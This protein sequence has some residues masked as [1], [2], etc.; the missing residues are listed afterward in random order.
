MKILILSISFTLITFAQISPNEVESIEN[1]LENVDSPQGQF[2]AQN[3][4]STED[5]LKET[6]LQCALDLCGAPSTV[7]SVYITNKSF[8]ED[9]Q[10]RAIENQFNS[11]R[12]KLSDVLNNETSK[13]RKALERIKKNLADDSY[14]DVIQLDTDHVGN[15][16]SNFLDS[17][18]HMQVKHDGDSKELELDI[19]DEQMK[20]TFPKSLELFE[21]HQKKVFLANFYNKVYNDYYSF[22]EAKAY[23]LKMR[24]TLVTNLEKIKESN[25]QIYTSYQQGLNDQLTLEEINAITDKNEFATKFGILDAYINN[26][27][28]FL[29]E[30]ITEYQSYTEPFKCEEYFCKEELQKYIDEFKIAEKVA[31]FEAKLNEPNVKDNYLNQCKMTWY[32]DKVLSVPE[33]NK[34]KVQKELPLIKANILKNFVSPLSDDSRTALTDYLRNLKHH[35]G[36]EPTPNNPDETDNPLDELKRYLSEYEVEEEDA[37]D[38][39]EDHERLYYD[40]DALDDFIDFTGEL[41]IAGDLDNYCMKQLFKADD[42]FYPTEDEDESVYAHS[43]AFTCEHYTQGKQIITHEFGH[44]I[45]H[46]FYIKKTSEESYQYYLNT[47]K[48]VTDN[49]H[50]FAD[51]SEKL[52]GHQDDHLYSEEDFADYLAFKMYPHEKKKLLFCSL[53]K[54]ADNSDSW[55]LEDLNVVHEKQLDPHSTALTRTLME[56]LYKDVV[57]SINCKNLMNHYQDKIRFNKCE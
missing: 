55:D 49:Y 12:E 50:P 53:L 29:S 2:Q 4:C 21:E 33:E 3:C 36:T 27:N 57:P 43:S 22:D 42:Y 38:F 45:S 31:Q 9:I 8:A 6:M 56:A 13:L 10:E 24:D 32:L 15:L 54:P 28:P 14:Q 16:V 7:D 11:D 48:C 30:P 39:I 35:F 51:E 18:T 44:A 47:R 52:M 26:I 17:K 40:L 41:N 23:I 20:K 46:F 19:W 1:T 5:A 37:Y 25:P 34:A